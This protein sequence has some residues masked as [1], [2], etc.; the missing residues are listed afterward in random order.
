MRETTYRIIEVKEPVSIKYFCD[1]CNCRIEKESS[2]DVIKNKI[3]F[4]SGCHYPD[5]KN[6]DSDYAY[7]CEKCA[8]EIKEILEKNGVKFYHK[9]VRE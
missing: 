4:A 9:E 6:I 5:C 3:E 1:R 8:E 2:Y 7:L